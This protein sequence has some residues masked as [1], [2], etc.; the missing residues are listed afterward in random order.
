[1]NNPYSEE[2]ETIYYVFDS[3]SLANWDSICRKKLKLINED[4][5]FFY[6]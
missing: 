1:L 3:I 6:E 4:M 2:I 5:N